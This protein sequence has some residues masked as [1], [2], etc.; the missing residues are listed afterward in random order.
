MFLRKQKAA[1]LLIQ[2]QFKH[3]ERPRGYLSQIPAYLF[4]S[5]KSVSNLVVRFKNF[6]G[7]R[8][9]DQDSCKQSIRKW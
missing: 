5:Q 6:G 9:A 7:N 1:H 2:V 3:P 8:N 4:S